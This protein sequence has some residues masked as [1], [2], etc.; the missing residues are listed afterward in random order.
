[1]SYF[2]DVGSDGEI[3]GRGYSDRTENPLLAQGA[4]ERVWLSSEPPAL[5]TARWSKRGFAK[6]GDPPTRHHR[7]NYTSLEWVLDESAA[8]REVRG[9]RDERMAASDWVRLRAADLGEPVPPEWLDYRQALRDITK[10]AD[11]LNIVWPQAPT[12]PP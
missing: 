8:W 10:Q 9:I 1:M 6:L 12:N 11:P 3:F 7:F 5:G 4:V 2:V